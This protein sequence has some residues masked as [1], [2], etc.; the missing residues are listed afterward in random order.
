MSA[1]L[2]ELAAL[3]ATPPPIH[4]VRS[5]PHGLHQDIPEARYHVRELGLASKHALDLVAQSPA[6][7]YAWVTG[8]GEDEDKPA[9]RLG[10]AVHCAMLEPERFMREYQAEPEWGNCT[11]ADNKARRNAWR[12]E[13]AGRAMVTDDDW[14]HSGVL[15][16]TDREARSVRGMVEAVLADPIARPL[17]EHSVAEV[18]IRWR[19]PATGVECKARLDMYAEQFATIPEL[20]S[21]MDARP[22]A[23]RRTIEDFEYHRQAA[24]YLSGTRAVD[25]P[26][27]TVA[28]IAV[29]K[30]AH[31]GVKVYDL[32][33]ESLRLGTKENA[34]N[35]ERLAAALE[36]GVWD[37]YPTGITTLSLSKWRL[38]T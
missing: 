13:R 34:A 30:T 6:H 1:E 2:A 14:K 22:S 36:S 5:L 29:E 17:L 33:D 4:G 27:E 25:R 12:S 9:Y 26:A 35:L 18:T 38:Q 8:A 3:L 10:R 32:D 11:K 16:L 7:Y 21:C 28:F 24:M 31:H 15:C 37:S 20:K 19:D 23:F